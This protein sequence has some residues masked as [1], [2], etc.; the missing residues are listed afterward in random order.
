MTFTYTA[1]QIAAKPF[2]QVRL[3]IG[4]TNV[5]SPLMEDE[6]ITFVLTLS[7]SIWRAAARCCRTI[8][9]VFSRDADSVQGELHILYQSRARAYLALAAKYDNDAVA[10]GGGLPYAGG[11]S[12][13]DKL[14]QVMN[15]DRVPPQFNLGEDLNLSLP[16]GPVGNEIPGA[17]EP[18]VE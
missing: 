9:G 4:D 1:A 5:K 2:M 7:P 3:L 18:V 11:I 13:V 17:S 14:Q 12:V 8:A 15:S 10:L 6:E 16:V